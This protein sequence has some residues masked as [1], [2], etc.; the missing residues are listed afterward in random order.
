MAWPDYML[1]VWEHAYIYRGFWAIL[2]TGVFIHM[3]NIFV[4]SEIV[5]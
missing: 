5:F 2:K 4:C 1:D 3:Q